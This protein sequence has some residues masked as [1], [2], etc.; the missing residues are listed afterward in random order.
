MFE[1]LQLAPRYTDQRSDFLTK[2]EFLSGTQTGILPS[3]GP[4]LSSAQ[5]A[6]PQSLQ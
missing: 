6:Q 2:N 3:P 5:N 1:I 4:A